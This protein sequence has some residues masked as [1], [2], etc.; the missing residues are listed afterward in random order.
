MVAEGVRVAV[1][2]MPPSEL[3]R[4]ER[5]ALGAVRSAVVKPVTASEKVKVMV[6]VSPLFNVEALLVMARVGA[7]VSKVRDGVVPAPP[8]L[9]AASL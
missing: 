8:L 3:D 4:F 9:P 7:W 5:A 2:V 6:A 1:Q